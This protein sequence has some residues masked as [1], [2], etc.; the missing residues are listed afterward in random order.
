MIRG[1][2]NLTNKQSIRYSDIIFLIS[3]YYLIRGKFSSRFFNERSIEITIERRMV[4]G[5]N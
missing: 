5:E 2:R 4:E 3:N 1:R